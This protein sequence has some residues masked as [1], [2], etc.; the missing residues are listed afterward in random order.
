M[1]TALSRLVRDTLYV[2]PALV[3]GIAGLVLAVTGVALGVSLL[4]TVVGAFV[5][6]ATLYAVRG[7][8]HLERVRLGRWQGTAAPD[9]PY[10]RARADDGWLRRTTTPL[11]D[12]QAWRDLA[13]APLSFVSGLAAATLALAWWTAALS[14]TTY[15]LW[16]RWLPADGDDQGL[17]QLLGLGEGRGAESLLHLALG[18]AAAVTLP[19]V[20]RGC[21]ALHAGLAR[22]LLVRSP[23]R[24]G[25]RSAPAARPAAASA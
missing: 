7:L 22:G 19:F 2:V 21:A 3:L 10:L 12:P 18:L 17:A 15:W 25:P 11:R 9:A 24:S 14:G 4:F 20:V 16:Q 6:A 13:W 8:A 5:L 23:R 1:S